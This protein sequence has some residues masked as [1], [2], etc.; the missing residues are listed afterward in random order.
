[1][2]RF[3]IF[4]DGRIFVT[5]IRSNGV[6]SSLNVISERNGPGGPLLQPYPDWMWTKKGDCKGITNVPKVAVS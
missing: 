3:Y 5:I 6:P 2:E 1:M 4:S